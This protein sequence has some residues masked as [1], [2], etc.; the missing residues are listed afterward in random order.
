VIT[1]V[2]IADT[3]A[4][5][6]VRRPTAPIGYLAGIAV[7]LA[8]LVITPSGRAKWGSMYAE[9]GGIF[10]PDALR[11]SWPGVLIHPYA[12]Y[13]HLVPR[14]VGGIAVLVPIGLAPVVF[15]GASMLIRALLAAFV[16]KAS[17]HHLG[18]AAFRLLAAAA[19]IAVPAGE[20][21][22]NI[23]NIHWYLI[24]A[25]FWAVLWRPKSWAGAIT[26][27][28]VAIAAVDSD[29]LTL[30]LAPLVLLRL[31]TLRGWREQLV[32]IGFA[33]ASGLQLWVALHAGGLKRPGYPWTD[34]P[35]IAAARVVLPFVVGRTTDAAL[36]GAGLLVAAAAILVVLAWPGLT[37]GP[38]QRI[39][40]LG[41]LAV[42]AVLLA[43]MWQHAG[44]TVRHPSR[45]LVGASRYAVT[46]TILLVSALAASLSKYRC[47]TKVLPALICGAAAGVVLGT[48]LFGQTTSPGRAGPHWRADVKA[49]RAA[50]RT[51]GEPLVPVPI[52]PTGWHS[53]LPCSAL[54]SDR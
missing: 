21:R 45:T 41:V 43:V 25:A 13:M 11:R 47:R 40:V 20:T 42:D 18:S 28:V 36:T 10:L 7:C 2:P 31:I 6:T 14:L 29:P 24:A 39:V 37:A 4:A 1:A 12:G 9:D 38:P 22:D 51:T 19:F 44:H 33:A 34:M 49:A 35:G 53:T 23:A 16:F 26:A 17:E 50:C 32:S 15:T 52:Y 27:M 5:A 3:S 54:R 48:M 30:A 8:L 46:P